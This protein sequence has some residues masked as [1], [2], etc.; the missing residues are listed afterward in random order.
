M[1]TTPRLIQ[2]ATAAALLAAASAQAFDLPWSKREGKPAPVA[3]STAA[4]LPQ[5]P[6]GTA[7]N[8]RAIVQ[9]FGPAVV[10]VNVEG[11]RRASVEGPEAELMQRFFRGLP[12]WRGLP[13]A[14]PFRGQGSGF[15]IADDGLI[16]TN[17]HVVKDAKE[18]TVRLADR[19]EFSAKVLG[20]DSATDI[21]V[22][23]IQAKG[24]PT[25]RIGDPRQLMVGDYVLA[26]GAPYGLEQTATSG[27]VSAKGRS[28]PGDAFVPFIQTDAAV[29]P[30][31]SGGPLFDAAGNV[32]GINAQIYSRTGGFQGV[33]FAIPIDVALKVRDQIVATGRA[34]HARLGV[35]VQDLNQAL[36]ESFGLK[37]PDGAVVAAVDPKSPAA[38]AGLKPGDVILALDGETMAQAGS[39]SSR[40]G[41]SRPGDKVKIKVWRDQAERE[42]EA[43]L[44]SARGA[45][46]RA[47]ETAAAGDQGRLGLS[48][49]PLTRQERQRAEIE[50]GLVVQGVQ[51]AA[52][53]AGLEPGDVV[54]AING[55]PVDALDDVRRILDAKPRS[56]AL[57]VWREGNRLFIP[58]QLG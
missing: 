16:L 39:V 2:A 37:K 15:I 7:P 29:N 17:A 42:L 49:R 31:N 13:D 6:L 36:A 55:R 14:Q 50:N 33:S 45:D 21:A 12:G 5:L 52:A 34:Q 53:R 23:R 18:V 26:I 44:G 8:Y 3:V 32:V 57:L 24:L 28:L 38:A 47:T 30:G 4:P 20:A 40:I 41:L 46:E 58:V 48:L 35:Q 19:R 11:S 43:T 10:G 51:G 1:R 54:L 56:V 9:Q 25:V 22:L 27:I